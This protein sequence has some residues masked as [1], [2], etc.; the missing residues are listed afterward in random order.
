MNISDFTLNNPDYRKLICPIDA[1][2][3]FNWL[4]F[5]MTDEDQIALFNLGAK[6]AIDFLEKFKWNKYKEL[7]QKLVDLKT[8]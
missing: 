8:E 3:K 5:N 7:R 4:D 6:K 2:R 1:D